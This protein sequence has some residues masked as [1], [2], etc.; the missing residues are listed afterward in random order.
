MAKILC[1]DDDPIAIL[2]RRETLEVAGYLATSC[3][4]VDEA[5]RELERE[6]YDAVVTDWR[7]S[8]ESGRAIVHTAKSK[9]SIP[10]VVVTGYVGEAFQAAEPLA[11]IYLEKPIDSRELIQILKILLEVRTDRVRSSRP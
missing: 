1:V 5:L 4:S 8:E 6:S 7:F 2:I 11:D 10:V 3:S 9:W